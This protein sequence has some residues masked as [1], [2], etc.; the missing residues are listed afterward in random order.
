MKNTSLKTKAICLVLG[1]TAVMS[2]AGCSNSSNEAESSQTP[3][4]AELVIHENAALSEGEEGGS[5]TDGLIDILKTSGKSL[6][7]GVIVSL[8]KTGFNLLL[9]ELG[10][11]TRSVE[12]KKLDQLSAKV[13][14]LKAMIATSYTNI[15]RKMVE[16]HNK[17]VLDGVLDKIQEVRTPIVSEMAGLV[18]ISEKE[19]D[20]SYDKSKLLAEKETFYKGLDD[21]KFA[22]LSVNNLWNAAENLATSIMK[23]SQSDQ[24]LKIFDLYDE[25][26]GALETWDYMTIKPRRQF[27]TYL[28]LIVN[29]LAELAKIQGSY[30]A[31]FYVEGD[32]NRIVIE[33]GLE[34]MASA[35]NELN[36][37]FQK[38]LLALDEIQKDHDQNR[39]MV[40][41][42]RTS[43]AEGNLIIKKDDAISTRLFPVN[44]GANEYNYVSFTTLEN[45]YFN[46]LKYG[47]WDYGEFMY[48]L[49]ASEY[50]KMANTI[51]T[52]YAQY[53][54]SLGYTDFAKYTVKDYLKDIGFVCYESD[55]YSQA[56]GFY[57]KMDIASWTEREGFQN[58]HKGVKVNYVGF[59]N[60]K[61]E[62]D[63]VDQVQTYTDYIWSSTDYNYYRGE[64]YNSWYLAFIRADS[65]AFLGSVK[66]MTI[67]Y[68]NSATAHSK[69]WNMLQK[70]YYTWSEDRGTC[71]GF[72]EKHKK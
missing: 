19:L 34:A 66:R 31:S 36:G 3:I 40:H 2:L 43:D 54:Q 26:F 59:Q 35:V 28:A 67:G 27:I 72:L 48:Y 22:K 6:V 7:S 9:N 33:K 4:A 23:P 8:A 71:L 17:D 25:T 51:V 39:H 5:F 29:S 20:E 38:E 37:E 10:F 58:D 30:K 63:L 62:S 18:S 16:I 21:V 56:K 42:T 45:N 57:S 46:D 44:P 24:N 52:E 15:T 61:E 47:Q 64:G 50:A 32:A 1:A 60:R 55:K 41:R 70:G 13:D 69:T 14:E 53:A 49:D 68:V 65:Q 11:D 12:E